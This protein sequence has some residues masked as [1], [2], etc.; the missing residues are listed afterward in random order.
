[1]RNSGSISA[2]VLNILLFS[3]AL[4]IPVRGTFLVETSSLTVTSPD[5]V[6]GHYD[7]AIGNFG[8]PQY[9]GTMSGT[10]VYPSKQADGCTPF[11]ESFKKSDKTGGRP[12]FALVDRG[13]NF[14]KE[15]LLCSIF[16]NST[17]VSVFCIFI[18][19][20]SSCRV[21]SLERVCTKFLCILAKGV[22]HKIHNCISYCSMWSVA[23]ECSC[24]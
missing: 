16:S 19:I 13:G 22:D 21:P 8:M 6:K 2:G 17:S 7:S 11:T 14:L 24:R 15:P 9:G 18:V 10:V 23:S 3:L 5:S 1:M 4:L 20:G 12:V